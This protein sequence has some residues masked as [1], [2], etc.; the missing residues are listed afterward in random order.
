MG[1]FER[2]FGYKKLQFNKAKKNP[3]EPGEAVAKNENVIRIFE[4][5][6]FIE[7]LMNSDRY[8]AKSDYIN[9][10]KEYESVIDFFNVLKSSEMMDDFLQ[11]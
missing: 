9:K 4:L 7:S 5:K 10:L 1:F 3:V 2:I 8:I 6:S 11:T